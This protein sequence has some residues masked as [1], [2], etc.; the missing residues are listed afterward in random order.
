[1]PQRIGQHQRGV[2][3]QRR[4]LLHL[5]QRRLE[6]DGSLEL[7]LFVQALE[8]VGDLLRL[9]FIRRRQQ[10]YRD[11]GISQSTHSIEPRSELKA[12]V[13]VVEQLPFHPGILGQ[14]QQPRTRCRAQ[15]L[16]AALQQVA[17]ILA[18]Q[19]QVSDGA[20]RHQVQTALQLG[21]ATGTRE[22]RLDNLVSNTHPGQAA[23]RIVFVIEF[24]VDQRQRRGQLRR[25]IVMVR[26]H[27]IDASVVGE[28]DPVDGGN[29]GIAGQQQVETLFDVPTQGERL[30]AV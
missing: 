19:R 21:G 15:H 30:N 20:D 16:H 25:Q 29:P 5:R 26:D 14:S 1:M 8:L 27:H 22:Q 24:R 2:L 18:L 3:A 28:R 12:D 9:R 23:Q 13:L 4:L 17:R 6:D 7:A 10:R 11:I